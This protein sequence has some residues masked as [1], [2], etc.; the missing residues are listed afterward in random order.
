MLTLEQNPNESLTISRGGGG[1]TNVYTDYT[2]ATPNE[3]DTFIGDIGGSI[4]NDG[5]VDMGGYISGLKPAS[6]M[7]AL[8]GSGYVKNASV[9][10]IYTEV[11]EVYNNAKKGFFADVITWFEDLFKA[12]A[13]KVT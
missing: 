12:I 11:G 10:Q 9:G 1:S 2:A 6:F 4:I 8:A 5:G 3:P 7:G 13:E